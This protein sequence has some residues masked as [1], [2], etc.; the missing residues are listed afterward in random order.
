MTDRL[1]ALRLFIRVARAG[2]F[3]AAARE[4]GLSQPSAS[5][6]VAGL[7]REVGASLLTRTTHRLVLTEVGADYL[8]RVDAIL[9]ALDEA[10]FVARG[11]GELRGLVRLAAPPN[12]I[13][14]EI[15]PGLGDF[16]DQHPR[17]RVDLVAADHRLNLVGAGIDVAVR[18]GEPPESSVV[19]RKLAEAPRLLV[20]APS[21]VRVAGAP[22]NPTDLARSAI[23]IGPA[24][25]RR[26]AWTFSRDGETVSAQVESR[27]MF[28]ETEGAIAAAVAGLG[29]TSTG[30]WGCRTE[31]SDG[32]LV[33]ILPDWNLG[34]VELFAVFAAGRAAKPS[35]R[36]IIDHLRRH[37]ALPQGRMDR[38]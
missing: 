33:Q 27:L 25:R 3:S 6:I 36:A 10:D 31:L 9:E 1:S 35:A 4:L 12:L 2:S 19:A 32:R 26:G 15:V 30:L 7:E 18:F 22:A 34:S 21:Y 14:R 5:R 38:H 16:L 11:G 8:A 37:V 17:L 20:A 13:A 28:S 23:L 29:I 24:G